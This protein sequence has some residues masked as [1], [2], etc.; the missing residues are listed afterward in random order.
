MQVTRQ[1][2]HGLLLRRHGLLNRVP[3]EQAEDLTGT[4]CGLQ[5]QVPTSPAA[6]LWARVADFTAADFAAALERRSLVR[7]WTVRGTRHLVR[8]ADLHVLTAAGRGRPPHHPELE[9]AVLDLLA[10]GPRTRNEL[11]DL[12]VRRLGWSARRS[13]E[14]FGQWGGFLRTLAL[15]GL[16]VDAGPAAGGEVAFAR[17]DRWLPVPPQPLD[18][19]EAEVRLLLHYLRGYG[20][21]TAAD[22]AYWAGI[23]VAAA[24]TIA[25]RAPDRLAEVA[26]AGVRG[27]CWAAPADLPALA[28]MPAGGPDPAPPPRLLPAFDALLLGR[29]DKESLL[30]ADIARHVFKAGAWVEPVALVGGRVAGT[31]RSRRRAR[32]LELHLTLLAPVSK[33]DLEQL[34]AE[35]EGLAAFLGAP[36][37]DFHAHAGP[38][39]AESTGQRRGRRLL[40]A[41]GPAQAVPVPPLHDPDTGFAGYAEQLRAGWLI[42]IP[43]LP[44]CA[45]HGSDPAQALAAAP[46]AVAAHM[47]WRAGRGHPGPAAPPQVYLMDVPPELRAL[48]PRGGPGT[49]AA[50]PL[51]PDLQAVGDPEW[52]D[53]VQV[54]GLLGAAVVETARRLPPGG[55]HWRAGVDGISAEALLERLARWL[56]WYRS[57]CLPVRRKEGADLLARLAFVLDDLTAELHRVAPAERAAPRIGGGEVWTFRMVLRLAALTVAEHLGAL[58][59]IMA[60]HGGELT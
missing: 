54:L 20:P 48:Q 36:A 39:D 28:A 16:V 12:A 19:D 22:F 15:R 58:E 42:H 5:A 45:A 59:V 38:G 34:R 7:T 31:W 56:G 26:V 53:Q 29:R 24:R 1:Q 30:A 57:R 44:G 40:A 35:A 21:A 51:P 60:A 8:P 9:S 49:M 10:D 4:L 18:P 27:P 23:T 37:V 25:A 46:A 43:A 55:H 50:I 11:Q 14:L 17:T 13:A 6:A 33:P 3:R 32:A 41:A 52:H 2:A 47:A